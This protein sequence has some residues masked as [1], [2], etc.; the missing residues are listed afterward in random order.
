MPRRSWRERPRCSNAP[1]GREAPPSHTLAGARGFQTTRDRS[2]SMGFLMFA[3][4]GLIIG[5]LARFIM[6]WP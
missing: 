5:A 4:F 6:P 3:I 2:I 1:R